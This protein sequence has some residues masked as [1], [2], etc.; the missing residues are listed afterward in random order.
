[1]SYTITSECITCSRC[2]PSCPTH[3]IEQRN[4][5]FYI[6]PN[7]CNDCQGY[8]RVAQCAAVCPTNGGCV[9]N[10]DSTM[11]T[12]YWEHWFDTYAQRLNSLLQG[13]AN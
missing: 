5:V 2:L 3:A 13:A 10:V 1:M 6:N 9:P 11:S 12:A 4:G 7:L 8:Y